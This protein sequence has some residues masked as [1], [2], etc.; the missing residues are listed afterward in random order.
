[1]NDQIQVYTGDGKG[2]TTAAFGLTVRAAGHG[3]RTYIGQFMKGQSCGELEALRGH[4]LITIE[5]YGGTGCIRREEVTVEDVARA[6]HGLER[7]LEA[8]LSGRHAIVVL[9][10]VNVAMWFGLLSTGEVLAFVDRRPQP[11][12]ARTHGTPCGPGSDRKGEPRDR[13]AGGQTLLPRRPAGP[14]RHRAVAGGAGRASRPPP[15]LRPA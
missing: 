6:R 7:A 11:G 2:K 9:D 15:G 14:R 10:E 3:L 8:M 12:G 13:D 4:P 1:V 5:Q